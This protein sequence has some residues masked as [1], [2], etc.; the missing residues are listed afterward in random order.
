MDSPVRAPWIEPVPESA[1]P[2][3]VWPAIPS[4]RNA[5]AFAI[6]AQ[7]EMSQWWPPEILMRQQLRQ[8]TQL[9]SFAARTVPFYRERLA[10]FAGREEP[11]TREEWRSIPFLTKE[12][13]RDADERIVTTRPLDG[14]GNLQRVMTSGSTG[15]PISVQWNAI[16]GRFHAG[17]TLRDH[18]WHRRDPAKKMA[19]VKRLRDGFETDTLSVQATRWFPGYRSGPT[20]FFDPREDIDAALDWFAREDPD[21]LM[22]YPTYLRSMILRS[23]ETGFRPDRLAEVATVSEAVDDQLRK[24]SDGYSTV[25]SPLRRRK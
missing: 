11:L 22:I 12:E 14:H 20:V 17:I 16:A 24:S 5:Q 8:A 3:I 7:L 1:V 13:L 21:Y 25:S 10:A 4:D 2:G 6:L 19:V 9:V 23:R 18:L 15:A